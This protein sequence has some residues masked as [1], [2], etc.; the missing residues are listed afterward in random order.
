MLHVPAS[1]EGGANELLRIRQYRGYLPTYLLR[2]RATA[3][4]KSLVLKAALL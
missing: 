4:G 2:K 1:R 3:V